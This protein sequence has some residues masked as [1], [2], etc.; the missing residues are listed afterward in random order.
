MN[1]YSDH[2]KRNTVLEGLVILILRDARPEEQ[3]KTQIE[4]L[5]IFHLLFYGKKAVGSR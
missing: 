1:I 5:L 3:K 4:S 2:D